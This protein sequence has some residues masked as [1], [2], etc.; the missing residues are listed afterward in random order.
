MFF[1]LGTASG[2]AAL[3][4]S[5]SL[6]LFPKSDK[7]RNGFRDRLQERSS[8]KKKR[9]RERGRKKSLSLP[10]LFI[11]S[12]PP[13]SNLSSF[14][15]LSLSISLKTLLSLFFFLFCVVSPTIS[16]GG[17]AKEGRGGRKGMQKSTPQFLLHPLSLSSNST[18]KTKKTHLFFPQESSLVSSS[19]TFI[20]WFQ[21][22]TS[23]F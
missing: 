13:L 23:L 4:L 12:R 1:S 22:K 19:S 18:K 10:T 21:K 11:F 15:S 14:S 5:L 2:P 9:E 17:R 6:F 20:I 8:K 16:R 3:F 7:K